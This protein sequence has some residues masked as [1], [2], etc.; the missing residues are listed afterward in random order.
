MSVRL[1][2]PSDLTAGTAASLTPAERPSLRVIDLDAETW[3]WDSIR[4]FQE[5]TAHSGSP[6][7]GW[8][9][10]GAPREVTAALDVTLGPPGSTDQAIVASDDFGTSMLADLERMVTRTSRH[11]QATMI[12]HELLTTTSSLPVTD[13]LTLESHAYSLLQSGPEFIAWRDS[14]QAMRQRETGDEILVVED[15][16][17][18]AIRLNRPDQRNAM[19]AAMRLALAD[20]LRAAELRE[21]TVVE[22]RGTGRHFSTGGDTTEFGTFEDPVSAHLLRSSWNVGGRLSGM[23]GRVNAYVQGACLGAGIELAAFASRVVARPGSYFGLPE[24]DLGLV[25]GA[26]GTVSLPRRIGRWRTAYMIYS[27]RL[28][29]AG[30]ARQWGLVDELNEASG[31]DR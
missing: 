22:L 20:A 7:V 6:L 21:D 11:P 9:T 10:R 28:V 16:G 14:R 27:G 3:S 12:A 15:P 31:R 5:R 29:P 1:E 23:S 19:N 30:I 25:P 24:L 4:R 8:T 13:A 18:M 17:Y 2:A 26:G